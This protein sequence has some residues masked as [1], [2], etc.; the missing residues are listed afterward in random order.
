M[1]SDSG[2]SSGGGPRKHPMD[3]GDR[4]G[5]SHEPPVKQRRTVDVVGYYKP[6]NMADT[7]GSSGSPIP[8]TGNYVVLR[9]L[10]KTSIFQYHVDF[11]PPVEEKMLRK[12]L[13]RDHEGVVGK[14]RAF[15]GMVLYLPK[16]LDEQTSLASKLQDGR[17]V[18]ICIRHTAELSPD[19]PQCLHLVNILFRRCVCVC[20]CVCVCARVRA[21]NTG[22]YVCVFVCSPHF[23][24]VHFLVCE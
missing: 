3:R 6:A 17:D 12:K 7:K 9:T 14:V 10:P 15:D 4:P 20:V 18:K 16:R 22:G 5:P 11:D 13:I 1:V 19:N 8:L 23:W 24:K 2:Q 21:L